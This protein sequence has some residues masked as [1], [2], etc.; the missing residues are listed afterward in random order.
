MPSIPVGLKVYFHHSSFSHGDTRD[1]LKNIVYQSYVILHYAIYY[2]IRYI[3]YI[4]LLLLLYT[5]YP[6]LIEKDWKELHFDWKCRYKLSLL[7]AFINNLDRRSYNVFLLFWIMKH[8]DECRPKSFETLFITW[9]KN[10]QFLATSCYT[11]MQ[12]LTFENKIFLLNLEKTIYYSF[13]KFVPI[14]DIHS[15]VRNI[16]IRSKAWSVQ[17]RSGSALYVS[18]RIFFR[19]SATSWNIIGSRRKIHQFRFSARALTRSYKRIAIN[20]R[21]DFPL[22][23]LI[24]VWSSFSREF[25]IFMLYYLRP[26][27]V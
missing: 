19:S 20:H 1:C 17:Q 22:L 16:S 9:L 15:E 3:S 25:I 12:L 11:F 13:W 4:I 2:T 23:R 8:D 26:V 21:H 10:S 18:H 24:F 7:L 27:Y 6:I 14:V 5:L